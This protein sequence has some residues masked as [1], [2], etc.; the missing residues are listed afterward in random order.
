MNLL[1]L[2]I[3]F[4][5]LIGLLPIWPYSTGWGYYPSGGVGLLLVFFF[6]FLLLMVLLLFWRYSG[7]GVYSRGGGFVLF[8]FFLLVFLLGRGRAL[9][10]RFAPPGMSKT[11]QSGVLRP[12]SPATKVYEAIGYARI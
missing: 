2:L 5:V 10:A 1:L 9:W 3:I 8:F 4:L 7:G 6:F 12:S 11:R